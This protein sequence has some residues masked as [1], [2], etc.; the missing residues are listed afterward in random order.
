METHVL[1]CLY[2]L[3]T[4]KEETKSKLLMRTRI[5][6]LDTICFKSPKRRKKPSSIFNISIFIF[7]HFK[8][9]QYVIFFT[10]VHNCFEQC[11]FRS[12]YLLVAEQQITYRK[13]LTRRRLTIIVIPEKNMNSRHSDIARE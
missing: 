8:F 13:A 3:W 2:F 7:V 5:T 9:D 6:F 4:R 1:Q 12:K 11:S 10:K